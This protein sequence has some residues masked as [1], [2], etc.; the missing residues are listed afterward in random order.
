MAKY[1]RKCNACDT[2]FEVTCKIAE[3]QLDI[4]CCP[5]CG[6]TNG[7]WLISAP[8][9]A[10]H[11]RL[12]TAKKDTGFKEVLQKIAERNPRTNITKQV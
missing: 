5:E 4:H 2:V 8:A 10:E 11:Q 1:D 7:E 12:S 9:L 6:R 3:K